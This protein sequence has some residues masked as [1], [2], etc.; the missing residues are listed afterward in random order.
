MNKLKAYLHYFYYILKHK[1]FVFI[2]AWREGLYKEAFTHDLSKFL[3]S[4]FFPYAHYFYVDKKRYQKDFDI[5]VKKHYKRNS[6][7]WQHSIQHSLDIGYMTDKE[8]RHMVADWNAM[9]KTKGGTAYTY[10]QMKKD[11]INVTETTHE[12]ILNFIM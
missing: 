10:Y 3:P 1:F 2:S 7:H 9:A 4:E 5:A 11:Q 6:H 8:V 12:K